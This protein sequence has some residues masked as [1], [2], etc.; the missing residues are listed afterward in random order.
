LITALCVFS[1]SHL[2]SQELDEDDSISFQE[3]QNIKIQ[4]ELDRIKDSLRLDILRE[5]L[6][7]TDRYSLE[8]LEK[9]K[10]E[11]DKIKKDDSIRHVLMTIKVD[12]LRQKVKPAY[13]TLFTDTIFAIYA[14]L[15]PFDAQQRA[16]NTQQSIFNLYN[17]PFFI[18]D[19]VFI[20]NK[21]NYIDI[22][23]GQTVL[24]SISEDDAI[25]AN[26]S[27]DSLAVEYKIRIISAI[28]E[29][30]YAHNFENSIIRW[31]KVVG[32]ALAFLLVVKLLNQFFRRFINYLIVKN[33]TFKKGLK[34]RQ[35]EL[36]SPS[37]LRRQI[38]QIIKFIR[39]VII[40]ILLYIA[41]SLIFSVF[42]RTKDWAYLLFKF[43]YDPLKDMG[44][45]FV[46]FI[47]DLIKIIIILFIARFVSRLLRYFSYEVQRNI[48][49]IKGFHKEWAAPTYKLLKLMVYVF[50][51]ILIF[52]LLPGA[53]TQEFKGVTVFLG[54]LLSLGSTSAISNTIAGFIITYM[55]PFK[56]GDWIKVNEI[57]GEVIE[58]TA[59]V[60]RIRT[61]NNEDVTVP[62][63]TILSNLTINYSS[64]LPEKNLCISV[65]VNLR[66]EV[67]WEKVESLLL[68]AAQQTTDIIGIPPSYVFQLQLKDNYVVYQLNAYT[69]KPHRMFHIKSELNQN[70]QSEFNAAGIELVAPA[71]FHM[72]QD[73]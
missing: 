27:M 10:S 53:D 50:A 36:I 2:F 61:L 8:E 57:T 62:N 73:S 41:L 25:W 65:N 72:N 30:R 51:F 13:V 18:S 47:P 22:M 38:V 21:L 48:L 6:S 55:R 42:P 15:G 35:Y 37:L 16:L 9:Y 26:T 4:K 11:L 33:K 12:S 44:R 59:L 3:I 32:I 49:K 56:V 5:E 40:L 71:H 66:Y 31:A 54:V 69:D 63:S 58:K 28:E 60:T 67:E 7:R 64:S 23:Y 68:K 14:S 1:L 52:P 45:A 24:S 39:I 70:I 43:V 46:N 17:A 20:D 19:S 34:V 29:N